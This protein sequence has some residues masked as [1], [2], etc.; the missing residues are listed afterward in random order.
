MLAEAVVDVLMVLMGLAWGTVS[1]VL[2]VKSGS[3]QPWLVLLLLCRGT[4]SRAYVVLRLKYFI[5]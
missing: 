1:E 5:D 3:V 2:A 4:T